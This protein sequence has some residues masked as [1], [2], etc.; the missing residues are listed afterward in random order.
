[1]LAASRANTQLQKRFEDRRVFF[2][3]RIDP[4]Y[5]TTAERHPDV[6]GAMN[7]LV[8][9]SWGIRSA[10]VHGDYSPKNILVCDGKIFLIDFE[11][12]HWG[13]P[14]FDAG[15]LLSH[16]FLKAL[17][18]PEC[19]AGYFEAARKFWEAF[20]EEVD[21]EE[22]LRAFETLTIWHASGLILARIDGKSPV[23]Y[24]QHEKTKARARGVAKHV[25]HNRPLHL[26]Q[27]IEI[28]SARIG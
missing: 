1:M 6:C 23:E 14:T 8:A 7:A 4:Y 21:D 10:L 19:A 2:Q 27:L 11:V 12:V 26:E 9:K 5:R 18:K 16:L 25:L 3:L 22:A 28:L 17:H 24:I 15:F 13:D 20:G